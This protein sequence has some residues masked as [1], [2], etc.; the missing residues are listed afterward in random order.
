MN[1]INV[2]YTVDHNYIKYMLVSLYSLL[3]NNS[4][5]DINIHII[6]DNF[7]EDDFKKI[8]NIVKRFQKVNIFF[9]SSTTINK[10]I[11]KYNIPLW[12]DTKI[13]NARVFFNTCIK[14]IDKILYLD[15]DT[16]VVDSLSS[17]ENHNGT[18]HMVQDSMPTSYIKSLNKSLKKYCNSGVLWIDVNKWNE[19]NCDQKIIDTLATNYCSSFPDQDLINIALHDDISLLPPEYNLL[20]TDAYFNTLFLY[21]YYDQTGIDRYTK[22]GIINAKKN[23]IILHSTPFYYWKPMEKNKIHPYS[24]IYD[25]YLVKIFG[26]NKKELCLYS[27]NPLLYKFILYSKLACPKSI[28]EPIK[29]LVRK[30][31]I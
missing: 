3:E 15:A 5:L 22:E 27:P 31:T 28:K 17:L 16:V 2:L 30:R 13:A 8:E 9:Y 25:E 26:E 12:H 7:E 19:N 4:N 29:D 18:I 10:L 23:P 14:D 6:Y 11:E 1:K 21:R 20:A 24:E